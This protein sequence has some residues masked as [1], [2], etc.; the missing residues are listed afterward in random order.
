MNHISDIEFITD[1]QSGKTSSFRVLVDRYKDRIYSIVFRI[2]ENAHDAEDIAQ[3]TFIAA[4][5]SIE[6]FDLDRKFAP[7]LMKIATNLSIDHLRRKKPQNVP[8]D[9]LEAVESQSSKNP[10]EAV[11]A[12]E[13]HQL[14]E[15]AI[16]QLPIKYRAA[17]A[18]YYTEEL[19]Y[20]EIAD[21]LKVPIGTVKTHLHRGREILKKR[22]KNI[23]CESVEA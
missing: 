17:V 6:S 14:T 16:R 13:L 5:R 1:C 2:V 22:L 10:L 20:D 12:S 21:A 18:L 8:L 4:Y 3:E 15:Q 19:T 7:W 11:E 9:S 23:L